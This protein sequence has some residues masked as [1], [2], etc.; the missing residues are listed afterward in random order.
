ME[1]CLTGGVRS[2]DDIYLLPSHCWRFDAG[3]AVEHPSADEAVQPGD[4]KAPVGHTGRNDHSLSDGL[5]SVV[6]RDRVAIRASREAD[7]L[8]GEHELGSEQ[9]RLLPR[10]VCQLTSADAAC[11]AQIVADQRAGAGLAADCQLLD[12]HG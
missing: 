6:Q 12:Y 3:G 7:G 1:C 4:T 2:T 9:H 11:E 8:V 10:P 5:A